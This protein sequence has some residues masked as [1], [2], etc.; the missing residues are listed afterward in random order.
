[1]KK[2]NILFA[3]FCSLMLC[4]CMKSFEGMMKPE[5]SGGPYEVYLVMPNEMKGSA[6]HDTL[7]QILEYPME[8]TPH[9]DSYFKTHHISP[10]NFAT[11][12]IRIV[13]NVVLVDIDPSNA[14]EPFITME[15]DKY[16]KTQLIV[17]AHAK[18]EESLAEYLPTIQ[19][20]LRNIFV[21]V[22]LNRRINI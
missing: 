15:K 9:G 12:V 14:S 22:E 2:L 1:M 19:E 21:S 6:V 5:A 20:K 7:V 4:G 10:E 8:C 13:G 18:S 17:K 3:I 16:S 11:Q